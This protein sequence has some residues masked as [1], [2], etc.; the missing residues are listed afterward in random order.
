MIEKDRV[1]KQLKRLETKEEI[2]AREEQVK[3]QRMILEIEKK[4]LR[5]E[6]NEL[7]DLKYMLEKRKGDTKSGFHELAESN[8]ELVSL[9]SGDL[10]R[11]RSNAFSRASQRSKVMVKGLQGSNIPTSDEISSSKLGANL[12]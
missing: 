10:F 2:V 1:T 11:D 9:K 4:K 3:K 6:M 5:E 8:K 12:V 7:D